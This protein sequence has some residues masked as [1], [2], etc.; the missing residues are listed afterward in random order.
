[1]EANSSDK[2]PLEIESLRKSNS[3]KGKLNAKPKSTKNTYSCNN[4]NKVRILKMF[5]EL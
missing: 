2:Y 1:M 5:Y 4:F 3:N